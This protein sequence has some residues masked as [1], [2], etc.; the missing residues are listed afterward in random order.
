M[1]ND[2]DWISAGFDRIEGMV[3][4]SSGNLS[5][6]T[7]TLA[8]GGFSNGFRIWGAKVAPIT[9]PSPDTTPVSGDDAYLGGFLFPSQAIRT[10][11]LQGARANLNPNAILGSGNVYNVGNGTVG[12]ID[13]TPFNPVTVA[14]IAVSRA[15]SQ[16]SG[17]VGNGIFS[18]IIVA[19]AQGIPTGR[20]TLAERAAGQFAWDFIFNMSDRF[21]WG[22]TYIPATH[23]VVTASLVPWSSANRKAFATARGDGVTTSFGPLNYTPASTSLSDVVIYVNGYRQT[24]GVTI[25][26]VT[27]MV[28]F[29]VAP[30]AGAVIAF[31]YDNLGQ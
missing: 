22:E 23:G 3:L 20:E 17:N 25:N 19:K 8:N 5:G 29:S 26:T 1:A 6:T 10:F 16:Q 31:Y 14:L 7:T 12:F 13:V 27:K 9:V 28:T 18:G 11:K 15:Q 30:L 21:P 2:Q 24:S 4:D